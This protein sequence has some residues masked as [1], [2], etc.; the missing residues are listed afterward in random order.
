MPAPLKSVKP[1]KQMQTVGS[2]WFPFMLSFTCLS[3]GYIIG[4]ASELIDH[5][6]SKFAFTLVEVYPTT[7]YHTKSNRPFLIFLLHFPAYFG[8]INIYEQS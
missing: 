8:I 2:S 5:F 6:F 4:S 1:T 7:K 3:Y